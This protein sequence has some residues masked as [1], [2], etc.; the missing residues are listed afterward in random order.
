MDEQKYHIIWSVS[1]QCLN[2]A[3]DLLITI[4]GLIRV[5]FWSLEMT[6]S[7]AQVW[8]LVVTSRSPPPFFPPWFLI[9]EE[10]SLEVPVRS[11]MLLLKSSSPSSSSRRGSRWR[12]SPS[13]ILEIALGSNGEHSGL[14][15]ASANKDSA[16][17]VSSIPFFFDIHV[18]INH[19]GSSLNAIVRSGLKWSA[20]RIREPRFKRSLL[21][22]HITSGKEFLGL[23]IEAGGG[24]TPAIR[25]NLQIVDEGQPLLLKV[26]TWVASVRT[27]V[28]VGW[29]NSLREKRGDRS[30]EQ[31]LFHHHIF[32]QRHPLA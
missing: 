19:T 24:S 13:S 8:K 14:S 28:N 31:P 20:V 30:E 32:E 26:A 17:L 15:R 7:T 25:T 12:L 27:W 1:H 2:L 6:S 10:C 23:R 16:L 5:H 9:I 22:V 3:Y 11:R 4:F 21:R 18:V 29:V